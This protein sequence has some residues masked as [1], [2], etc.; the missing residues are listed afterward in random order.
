MA[1]KRL[2]TTYYLDAYNVIHCSH[3]L[4]GIAQKSV[5]SARDALIKMAAD[6]CMQSGEKVVAVFDGMGIPSV[7]AN[8][9]SHVG[10]LQIVYCE[11]T[12]SA[13]T[14]IERAVFEVPKKLDA[15]VVT[16]DNTVAQSARGMGALVLKPQ[17]FIDQVEQALSES[18]RRRAIPDRR[19]FG[20]GF[21]GRLDRR[22]RA[23]L[24][25]LRADLSS[26]ND[27]LNAGKRTK[28]GRAGTETGS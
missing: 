9:A 27:R 23:E 22:S 15:V 19:R 3:S 24:E 28:K 17:S 8:G 21:S 2:M 4:K 1:S 25:A 5:V 11:G 14:Y 13:D 18:R 20:T 16:A 26:Q 6:Y 7:S 12:M 10:N